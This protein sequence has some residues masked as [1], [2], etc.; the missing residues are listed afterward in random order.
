MHYCETELSRREQGTEEGVE[1]GT[2]KK[3][4]WVRFNDCA[5]FQHYAIFNK[6]LNP[7]Y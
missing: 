6:T 3:D 7:V 2:E 1:D 4:N 5:S